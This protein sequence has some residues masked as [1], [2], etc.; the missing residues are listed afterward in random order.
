MTLNCGHIVGI[1][2]EGEGGLGGTWEG[3]G[4]PT[5]NLMLDW[6]FNEIYPIRKS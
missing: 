6:V 5:I 2:E 4:I 1:C 3:F